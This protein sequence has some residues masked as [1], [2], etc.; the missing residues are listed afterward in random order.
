MVNMSS[1]V[2]KWENGK[3]T[4]MAKLVHSNHIYEGMFQD[5]RPKGK[6]KYT[7]ED[8]IEQ[9]GFYTMKDI[10]AR[11][12]GMMTLVG[13]KPAWRSTLLTHVLIKKEAED[14]VDESLVQVDKS[15]LQDQNLPA[16]DQDPSIGV[17][18]EVPE[19]QHQDPTPSCEY[20]SSLSDT[21]Q[22]PI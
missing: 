10:V 3:Q 19:D 4:G 8:G 22:E 12:Q 16:E 6:G 5:N 1:L 14:I 9:H 17:S 21:I 20:L 11:E 13:R 7:F 2:A 18:A 15:L